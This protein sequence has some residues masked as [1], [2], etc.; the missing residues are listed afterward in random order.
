MSDC[1]IEYFDS[2]DKKLQMQRKLESEMIRKFGK[3]KE[4]KKNYKVITLDNC[5][6]AEFRSQSVYH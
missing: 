5:V 4:S 6:M 2:F 3:G 1:V